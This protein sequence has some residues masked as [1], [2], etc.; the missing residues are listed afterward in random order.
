MPRIL[1]GSERTDP[2][3]HVNQILDILDGK[4]TVT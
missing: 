1:V 4:A 2:A 3:F